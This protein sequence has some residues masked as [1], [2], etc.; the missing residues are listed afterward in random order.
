VS[1]NLGTSVVLDPEQMKVGNH[2]SMGDVICV[3]TKI[4]EER[5]V[6]SPVLGWEL[7][8]YRLSHHRY[9]MGVIPLIFFLA[10]LLWLGK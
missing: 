7:F 9:L 2:V 4:E 8:R 5:V 1:Y 10:I 6:L 3:I